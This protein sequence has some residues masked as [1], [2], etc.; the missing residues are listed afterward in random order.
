MK[1]P[2]FLWDYNLSDKQIKNILCSDNELEK[3]WLVGRILTHAR[4]EDVWKYLKIDEIVKIFPKLRL[5]PETRDIWKHAL[6]VWN[7]H[8]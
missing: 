1:R 8:V 2:Y 4:Y 7:Y 3:I 5:K 6:N